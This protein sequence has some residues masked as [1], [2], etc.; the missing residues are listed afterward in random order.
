[1]TR[2][3][4]YDA[5]AQL[6]YPINGGPPIDVSGVAPAGYIPLDATNTGVPAGTTLTPL[7][8]DQVITVDGTVLENRDIFGF[9]DVR[10]RDVQ[11]LTSRVRGSSG[12]TG[13]TGLIAAYNAAC[14][15]LLVDHCDLIPDYPSY[16][17]DGILGD[18]YTARWCN[19]R[20]VVDGFGINGTGTLNTAAYHNWIHDLA[21]FSPDPNHSDNHTHND[22]IQIFG[23]SGAIVV[24]NR[25]DCFT[26]TTVGTL[27][28]P[29]TQGNAAIQLNQG[30]APL[31]G[32]WVTDNL[33]DGGGVTINGL[34]VS[35]DIG[36]IMRNLFGHGS[37]YGEPIAFASAVVCDTGSGADLNVYS[38]TGNPVTIT[39]V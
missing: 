23:G 35:G 12:G 8:G 6:F 31:T 18:N 26:S 27:N 38:D 34:G 4:W 9:V 5:A 10:A 1:M 39:R 2:A 19:V 33:C 36:T 16:W 37:Y 20:N 22:C 15:N 28:N 3:Y 14:V 11:I 32:L 17:L 25:L 30:T 13:N 24:A 7:Y 21:W 29:N